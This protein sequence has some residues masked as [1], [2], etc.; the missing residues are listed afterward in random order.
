MVGSESC[1]C[2]KILRRCEKI[3]FQESLESNP[4]ISTITVDRMTLCT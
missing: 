4:V 1:C 3:P 2:K